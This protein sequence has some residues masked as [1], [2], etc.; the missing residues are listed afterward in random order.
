VNSE[1]NLIKARCSMADIN[2][3]EIGPIHVPEDDT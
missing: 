1:P 2:V 3:I